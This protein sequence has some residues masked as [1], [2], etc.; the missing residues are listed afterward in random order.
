M[1]TGIGR[2]NRW[3]ARRNVVIARALYPPVCDGL[4]TFLLISIRDE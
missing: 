2:A 1:E 3:D 4:A